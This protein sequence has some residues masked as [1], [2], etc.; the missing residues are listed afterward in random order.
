MHAHRNEAK[1]AGAL[2]HPNILKIFDAGEEAGQ[3]Y[4]VME[5]IAEARTLR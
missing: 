4:I 2:D 3:P 1:A 5:Y